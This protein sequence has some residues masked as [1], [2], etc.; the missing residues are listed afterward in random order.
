MKQENFIRFTVIPR[1]TEIA[2]DLI[3]R[4]VNDLLYDRYI[5]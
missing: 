4:Y 2:G 5:M 3:R 1:S